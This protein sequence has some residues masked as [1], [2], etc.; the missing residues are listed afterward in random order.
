M[1]TFYTSPRRTDR[2]TIVLQCSLRAPTLTPKI[3]S[4]RNIFTNDLPVLCTEPAFLRT[5][6]RTGLRTRPNRSVPTDPADVELVSQHF[7]ALVMSFR[8]Q[9]F[10][11]H[12]VAYVVSFLSNLW[13]LK[14][15]IIWPHYELFN[16]HGHSCLP[17]PYLSHNITFSFMALVLSFRIQIFSYHI[18]VYIVSFHS[19]LWTLKSNIIRP[20]YELFNAHGHSCP[21]LPYLSHNITFSFMAL[22]L[23]FRI[24]I[25]SAHIGAYIVSFDSHIWTLKFD[26]LRPRYE[27]C[28]G[29]GHCCFSQPYLSHN[30][31]FSFMALAL[32]FRI[33]IFSDHIVAY[34]VSFDSHIW[35]LKSDIIRPRYKLFNVL[36]VSE[37]LAQWTLCHVCHVFLVYVCLYSRHFMSFVFCAYVSMCMLWTSCH[38]LLVYVCIYSSYRPSFVFHAIILC[39]VCVPKLVLA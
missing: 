10:S 5:G 38:V 22:A 11:Y 26:I 12:I 30:I 19:H 17:L 13:T 18:V 23:S 14:S 28:D 33:W 2:S 3:Y 9:I 34:V 8:I 1:N 7:M 15:D 21:S 32:S 20:R 29:C 39:C 36:C 6:L 16:A 27:L 25:F 4:L 24:R 37:C 35:T 31:T